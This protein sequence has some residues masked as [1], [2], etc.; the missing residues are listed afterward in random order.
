M[1]KMPRQECR[2]G[3]EVLS[4]SH[5]CLWSQLLNILG[6]LLFSRSKFLFT[7]LSQWDS[8]HHLYQIKS[9]VPGELCDTPWRWV[10]GTANLGGHAAAERA[11]YART[12]D[13][14]WVL[15]DIVS[16]AVSCASKGPTLR[17]HPARFCTPREHWPPFVNQ[18]VDV[19]G[20]VS[21]IRPFIHVRS[22]HY[23]FGYTLGSPDLSGCT[24]RD[25]DISHSLLKVVVFSI[26][27]VCWNCSGTPTSQNYCRVW[28]E[29]SQKVLALPMHWGGLPFC[30]VEF[31]SANR[32]DHPESLSKCA[33]RWMDS[34]LCWRCTSCCCWR[35]ALL[36]VA[37]AGNAQQV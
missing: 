5:W 27:G 22:F 24:S 23:I 34:T 31:D 14:Q 9:F 7:N 11:P 10:V 25:H 21:Y 6:T 35:W 28:T 16:Q 8:P 19:I 18:G 17:S 36:G 30:P 3:H 4:F 20:N 37:D 2:P 26:I 1:F 32:P 12:C 13:L 33:G 15:T 29:T